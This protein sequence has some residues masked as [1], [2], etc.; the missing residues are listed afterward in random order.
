[1]LSNSHHDL[2][3]FLALHPKLR[4]TSLIDNAVVIEGYFDIDA[5]IEGFEKI[6][7]SYKVRVI[8]NS[9]F[10]RD[11]PIVFELENKI[12]S[13]EEFHVNSDGSLCMGSTIRLKSTLH[14]SPSLETFAQQILEPY[15]Y[16]ISYKLRNGYFPI[17]ELKHGIAGLIQDYEE[18][19]NVKG[20][21]AVLRV[22]EI[23]GSKERIA[24]KLLCPCGCGNRLGICSFRFS[25]ETWRRLESKKWYRNHHSFLLNSS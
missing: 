19:F 13:K 10:P 3:E 11:I 9:N 7:D 12:P 21:C 18:L 23:L 14:Q 5:K 4:L 24:N 1:M 25:L 17:G 2:V 16:S 15:L 20:K 8:L 6:E 22:L